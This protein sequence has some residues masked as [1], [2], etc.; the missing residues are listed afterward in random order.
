MT[1]GEQSE[2]VSPG[3]AC[4]PTW[5]DLVLGHHVLGRLEKTY[6]QW[7]FADEKRAALEGWE[8]HLARVIDGAGNIV[9]MPARGAA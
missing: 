3:C 1:F 7:D 5:P 8:A 2:R 6:I 4:S 9:P